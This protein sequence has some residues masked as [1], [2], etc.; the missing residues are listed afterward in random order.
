MF[1]KIVKSTRLGPAQALGVLG[2]SAA[3][4][5][6]AKAIK[7]ID[8]IRVEGLIKGL[9]TI[10]I[11]LGTIAVFAKVTKPAKLA[12]SAAGLTLMAIAIRLM[13]PPIKDL[14]NTR[15]QD[16]VTKRIGNMSPDFSL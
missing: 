4:I 10:G 3:M 9:G 11:L 7:D 13:V 5:V 8:N 6:M 2:I 15:W 12:A 14:G 16:L 1:A